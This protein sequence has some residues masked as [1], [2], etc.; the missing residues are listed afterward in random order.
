VLTTAEEI[1]RELEV[2]LKLELRAPPFPLS[3]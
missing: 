2:T 1:V 3:Q